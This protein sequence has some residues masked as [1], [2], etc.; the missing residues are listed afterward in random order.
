MASTDLLDQGFGSESEDDNFNPAPAE[1]S[2]N[3]AAGD[4]EAEN[5]R[6]SKQN[7]T[8]LQSRALAANDVKDEDDEDIRDSTEKVDGAERQNGP[9]EDEE[10]GDDDD[11]DG[12]ARDEEEEEEDDD[13]DEDEEE[14][15]SVRTLTECSTQTFH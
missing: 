7:G 12:E 3:E 11:V 6:N 4:S 14:V 9:L 2:E 5:H 15:V 13:D 8:H 10:G 1:D